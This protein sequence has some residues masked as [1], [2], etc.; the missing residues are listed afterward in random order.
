[1]KGLHVLTF[2]GGIAAGVAV[3]ILIAPEKGS[4]TRHR[5]VDFLEMRGIIV[6]K[7]K[8]E[9]IIHKVKSRLHC[10]YT[11]NDLHSVIERIIAEEHLK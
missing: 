10:G 1:M 4:R 8:L 2:L 7:E 9:E 6:G 11:E 5:I 3:G